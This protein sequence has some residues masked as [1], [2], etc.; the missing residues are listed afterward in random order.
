VPIHPGCWP[1]ASKS[2]VGH[3]CSH[4]FGMHALQS[5]ELARGALHVPM[6]PECWPL[7][8]KRPWLRPRC[9]RTFDSASAAPCTRQEEEGAGVGQRR[10]VGPAGGGLTV[11]PTRSA[12]LGD[13]RERRF[14]G[15]A[16]GQHGGARAFWRP[17]QRR[18]VDAAQAYSGG[19]GGPTAQ[20]PRAPCTTTTDPPAWP[21]PNH[22]P[23]TDFYG[24]G[25][26]AFGALAGSSCL[27]GDGAAGACREGT[28]GRVSCPGEEAVYQASVEE[29]QAV[30][31][32]RKHAGAEEGN[33]QWLRQSSWSGT[34]AGQKTKK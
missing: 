14:V 18:F 7:A 12:A 15:P 29:A 33:H 30:E 6:R 11:D 5:G 4:V 34:V 1:L 24:D 28:S 31:V 3:R 17:P 10:F 19:G 23:P 32:R 8:S 25:I 27:R 22:T 9:P 21:K 2:F 13:P 16:V 26:L 20:P